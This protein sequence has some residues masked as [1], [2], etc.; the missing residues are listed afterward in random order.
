MRLQNTEIA[1][2]F[3]HA[4]ISLFTNFNTLM[5]S[6]EPLI[7]VVHDSVTRLAKTLPNSIIKA[8][9]VKETN[10]AE[11]RHRLPTELYLRATIIN[12]YKF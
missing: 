8:E 1:L 12:G 6:D 9:V 3:Q 5:Q 2:P 10:V 7:H 4:S 11:L